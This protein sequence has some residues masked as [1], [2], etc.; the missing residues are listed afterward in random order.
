MLMKMATGPK[1]GEGLSRGAV[2]RAS[3]MTNY[4]LE[5]YLEYLE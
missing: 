4:P 2:A 5:G 3:R 1:E